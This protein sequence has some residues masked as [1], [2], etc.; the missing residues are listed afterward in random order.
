MFNR[1]LTE[2]SGRGFDSQIERA[3]NVAGHAVEWGGCENDCLLLDVRSRADADGTSTEPFELEEGIPVKLVI[4]DGDDFKG[5]YIDIP[6]ESEG[7]VS[8]WVGEEQRAAFLKPGFVTSTLIGMT[9]VLRQD[10]SGSC[11]GQYRFYAWIA[12]VS[13]WLVHLLFAPNFQSRGGR[14]EASSRLNTRR[15]KGK[16]GKSDLEERDL[17][18]LI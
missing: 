5:V 6:R 2:P 9:M 13:S 17:S 14:C 12:D 7:G 11:F 3:C 8:V 18:I 16:P 4:H 10:G 1:H 15:L